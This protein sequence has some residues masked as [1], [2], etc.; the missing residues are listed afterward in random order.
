MT[1]VAVRNRRR[2]TNRE[3][4][5][6]KLCRAL[7]SK[8]LIFLELPTLPNQ[9]D[10]TRYRDATPGV[11]GTSVKSAHS[12]PDPVAPP[13][14]LTRKGLANSF[15][16]MVGG[17]AGS[18]LRPLCT[19]SNPCLL[20]TRPDDTGHTRAVAHKQNYSLR[21]SLCALSSELDKL[22]HSNNGRPGHPYTRISRSSKKS[23]LMT[24]LS[25]S[26]ITV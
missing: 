24:E 18:S 17:S 22:P 20:C 1:A 12:P 14:R 4:A 19:K 5:P 26:T 9:S 11:A 13:S 6:C 8:S 16:F 2:D 23:R 15:C 3:T 21:D 25:H 10:D 7:I